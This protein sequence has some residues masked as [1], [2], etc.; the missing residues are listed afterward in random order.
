M[1]EWGLL[2]GLGYMLGSG[3]AK[4]PDVAKLPWP[5]EGK[6]PAPAAAKP[7]GKKPAQPDKTKQHAQEMERAMDPVAYDA[8][9]I[10]RAMNEGKA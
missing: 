4:A 8:A 3:R 1:I 2:F 7:A 5:Q 6:T 9:E 10:E